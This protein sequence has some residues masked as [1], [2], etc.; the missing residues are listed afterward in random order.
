VAVEIKGQD[1]PFVGYLDTRVVEATPQRAV[2][3]QPD[4]KPLGN[5]VGVRHASALYAAGFEAGRALVLA[6]LGDRAQSVDIELAGSDTN[7]T[8]VAMGPLE[9]VAEPDGDWSDGAG[10]L[11]TRVTGTDQ[12]GKTVCTLVARWRVIG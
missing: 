11:T 9:F 12:N 8:F 2:V 1:D 5:H 6:A 10:E 3:E 7:Y 4:F